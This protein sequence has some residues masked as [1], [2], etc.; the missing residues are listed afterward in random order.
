[1]TPWPRAAAAYPQTLVCLYVTCLVA[2]VYS[3]RRLNDMFLIKFF[4]NLG[5]IRRFPQQDSCC[6]T[7]FLLK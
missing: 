2:P 3:G 7:L 5:S 6:A 1:M 4:F